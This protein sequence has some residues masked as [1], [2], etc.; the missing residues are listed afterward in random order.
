MTDKLNT[1]FA[2]TSIT[3][4]VVTL[5][6]ITL[7]VG[8]LAGLASLAVSVQPMPR[9]RWHPPGPGVKHMLASQL[10]V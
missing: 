4:G 9:V 2:L 1:L 6:Q 3:I 5:D 7:V 10:L 8:I